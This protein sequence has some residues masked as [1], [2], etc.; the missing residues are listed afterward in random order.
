M[1]WYRYPVIVDL[2][3]LSREEWLLIKN[4]HHSMSYDNQIDM[5]YLPGLQRQIS[6]IHGDRGARKLRSQIV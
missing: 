4:R 2:R 1:N 5:M 6:G 3:I